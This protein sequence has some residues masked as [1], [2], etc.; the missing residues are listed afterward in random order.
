MENDNLQGRLL[1]AFVIVTMISTLLFF[2]WNLALTPMF[3][4][5]PDLKFG[6][7]FVIISV[8]F[9]I[10]NLLSNPYIEDNNKKIAHLIKM[11]ENMHA[12]DLAQ[13]TAIITILSII[14]NK[15]EGEKT[16]VQLEIKE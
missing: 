1:Y 8:V 14:N 9:F 3:P 5:L 13:R 4:T 16:Q 7:T 6:N 10:K 11:Y 15:M 2:G 12:N